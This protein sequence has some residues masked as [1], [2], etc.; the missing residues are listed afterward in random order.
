[1][2]TEAIRRNCSLF[3][4]AIAAVLAKIGECLSQADPANSGQRTGNYVF[5]CCSGGS[6]VGQHSFTVNSRVS[7]AKPSELLPYVLVI[8]STE[9]FRRFRLFLVHPL[10]RESISAASRKLSTDPSFETDSSAVP[11]G[12]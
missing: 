5:S 10:L 6:Q 3:A 9:C 12:G 11:T 2:K 4:F 7:E 8:P 1:M